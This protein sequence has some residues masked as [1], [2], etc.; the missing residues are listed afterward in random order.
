MQSEHFIFNGVSS[1]DMGLYIIRMD[2]GFISNPL[3]GSRSINTSVRTRSVRALPQGIAKEVISFDLQ[4]V[5]LDDNQQLQEWTPERR[6][7]IAKFLF[8]D[9]YASFQT[10]DD[11]GKIYYGMFTDAQNIYTLN[12]TGYLEL[13]FTTNANTA[14]SPVINHYYDLRNNP[15]TGTII[16]V[17]NLSN[18]TKKYE[19]KI[20]FVMAESSGLPNKTLEITNISNNNRIFKFEGLRFD[21]KISVD[22]ANRIILSSY[23]V[24][25][26]PY[27]KFNKKWLE[28]VYGLNMLKVK[29]KCSIQMQMQFPLMR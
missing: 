20:E 18:I 14:W 2:T 28:L 25:I 17:E 10:A 7:A 13:T 11:L 4:M 15:S 27:E 16:T 21:E 12:N 19:P 26:N 5:L 24:N 6:S 3:I 22:N 9:N 1:Q 8:S 29:G 23:P